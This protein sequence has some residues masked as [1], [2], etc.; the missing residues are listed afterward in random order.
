LVARMPSRASLVALV[1]QLTATVAYHFDGR[2]RL[3][4]LPEIGGNLPPT[5]SL[6]ERI[7]QRDRPPSEAP[8]PWPS[9]QPTPSPT[10]SPT[11]SPTKPPTPWP[12]RAPT[13]ATV[14]PT[15][16][17][18]TPEEVFAGLIPAASSGKL[19]E[20]FP[21]L[22]AKG[23]K[24]GQSLA[25]LQP[26]GIDTANG[27]VT[28]EHAP[29]S[30]P[31]Q[32]N[33]CSEVWMLGQKAVG[34]HWLATTLDSFTRVR[35][36]GEYEHRSK[37]PVYQSTSGKFSFAFLYSDGRHSWC[38]SSRIGSRDCELNFT[39]PGMWEDT[40]ES[41]GNKVAVTQLTK[42]NLALIS[43]EQIEFTCSAPA[44]AP[45]PHFRAPS[46]V[47]TPVP[48]TPAPI[49]AAELAKTASRLPSQVPTNASVCPKVWAMGQ[50]NAGSTWH[51]V[52]SFEHLSRHQWEKLSRKPVYK[53]TNGI[54]KRFLYS[55]LGSAQWCVGHHVGAKRC[56]FSFK[57]PLAVP[58][59]SGSKVTMLE[60]AY[61]N[62]A[63]A[64]AMG[65]KSTL[66]HEQIEFVCR[67]LAPTPGTVV[68][69]ARPC[70]MTRWSSAGECNATCGGG[71]QLQH[72]RIA[73]SA[74]TA[75]YQRCRSGPLERHQQCNEVACP[76]GTGRNAARNTTA[77][78]PAPV[79]P[80][81][82]RVHGT[83]PPTPSLLER[84][85]QR[86]R[87]PSEAP[88][89]WPSPQPTPSP[90]VS[91]TTSPT[92][93][94]TPWPTEKDQEENNG[95]DADSRAGRHEEAS[96]PTPSLLA[97][98]VERENTTAPTTA[99]TMTPTP[100]PTTSPT[101][102]PPTTA[103]TG[104]PTKE[105][106]T[107]PGG[108][109]DLAGVCEHMP[110]WGCT[111][112]NWRH[113]C[114][115]S[116]RTAPCPKTSRL[117]AQVATAK[118][119]LWALRRK[120]KATAL[121]SNA[122]RTPGTC[123]SCELCV[124]CAGCVASACSGWWNSKTEDC[125]AQPGDGYDMGSTDDCPTHPLPPTPHRAAPLSPGRH[126]PAGASG[127]T[128][129]VKA[130]EAMGGIIAV[131]YSNTELCRKFGRNCGRR[132]E[133]AVKL[134]LLE[135]AAAKAQ[136]AAA[137]AAQAADQVEATAKAEEKKAAAEEK[138][139]MAAKA[140]AVKAAAAAQAGRKQFVEH[141]RALSELSKQLR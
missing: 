98:I 111:Q 96:A 87:P 114:K 80:P 126:S 56:D 54:F 86:D 108:C 53:S 136:V 121:T 43:R 30:G 120:S 58:E 37:R 78:T 62:M 42:M 38:A 133:A 139:A 132:H 20:L 7:A 51:D 6:L 91:P 92:K 100:L 116:C 72:R 14:A 103:P 36:N 34:D 137:K 105:A 75:Q 2:E 19:L 63:S 69:S 70:T 84:I 12:T 85:A 124:T 125:R 65:S 113:A 46:P 122:T 47:P 127:R 27:P 129:T 33:S 28:I 118:Q 117:Y 29:S 9:P 25:G 5:P 17:P 104:S 44:P 57:S 31:V 74:G 73:R 16:A 64:Q 8:T 67:H 109:H 11:T 115:V 101:T 23:P 130:A 15:V 99:P 106:A 128:A 52:D 10:V 119:V 77:P 97:M 102:A 68:Q 60:S 135:A 141:P 61:T 81:S 107:F 35:A 138:T 89:P 88:T 83:P 112:T 50:K 26:R 39:S 22:I 24:Q 140:T 93:P 66:P 59:S 40:P 21:S 131:H 123:S 45:A 134:A 3:P 76:G 41:L 4:G 79:L 110:S 48:P 1:L 90:T 95:S 18:T 94:P 32:D 55:R 71:L 13:A 82:P 49:P